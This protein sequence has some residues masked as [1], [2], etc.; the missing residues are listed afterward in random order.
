MRNDRP[1]VCF[2]VVGGMMQP[3]G[4]L[5][6][7]CNL[8]DFNMDPQSALDAPRFRILEDGKLALEDGIAENVPSQLAALGHNI[9]SHSSEE[10]LGGG[11]VIVISDGTLFGGSDHRKDGCAIGY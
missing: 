1:W 5:Q 8:I 7:A 10:G 2:G 9:K 11:Q 4:H 6:V 3:Q